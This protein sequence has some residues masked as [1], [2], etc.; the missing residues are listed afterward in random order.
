MNKK[1]RKLVLVSFLALAFG[2]IPSAF[3]AADA[4]VTSLVTTATDSFAAIKVFVISIVVFG[5]VLSLIKL[6]KRR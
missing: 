5:V 4:D 1:N 2:L 6:L 3:A